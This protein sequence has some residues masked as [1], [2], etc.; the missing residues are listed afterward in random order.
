[1]RLIGKERL[2]RLRGISDEID[3]WTTAWVSELTDANWSSSEDLN[4]CFPRADIIDENIFIFPIKESQY[5][6]KM[7]IK[8]KY[9]TALISE[10]L[11]NEKPY[12]N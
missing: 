2:Q 8:F 10:I 5:N 7:I 12:D 4:R 6:I 1:M 9:G 11:T 3:T